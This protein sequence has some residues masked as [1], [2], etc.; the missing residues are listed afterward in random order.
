[1]LARAT[2]SIALLLSACAAPADGEM[3]WVDGP[4]RLQQGPQSPVAPL[5]PDE[6]LPPDGVLRLDALPRVTGDSEGDHAG[7]TVAGAGDLNGDGLDDLVVGSWEDDEGG[8]LAGAAFVFHGPVTGRLDPA[9]AQA[10]VVGAAPGDHAGWSV[11]GAGDVNGDGFGDLVVGAHGSHAG[12]S[13]AGAAYLLLGPLEGTIHLADAD[14]ILLG[15]SWFDAA[16][17]SVDGAG[18]VNGD[19]FDD[20]VVGAYQDDTGGTDAGAAFVVYGPIEGEH[21]LDEVGQRLSG[22]DE[23]DWAGYA[24]RGAGDLNDDGLDDVLVSAVGRSRE[25]TDAGAVYVV[26]GPVDSDRSLAS[27]DAVVLGARASDRAGHA[28]AVAEDATGDGRPDLLVGAWG[29]DAEGDEAGGAWLVPGPFSGTVDLRSQ[30]LAFGGGEPGDRLGVSVASTDWNGDGVSDV[31]IGSLEGEG[32]TEGAAWIFLGPLGAGRSVDDADLRIE[33]E[34]VGDR[35]G[36]ALAGAG[37][38]DGDGGDD[39]IVGAHG[40]SGAVDGCGAA[41]VVPGR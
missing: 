34:V 1:M 22:V 24:V 7:W 31:V 14:A 20:L 8:D 15:A 29:H 27:A 41:Y 9:V 6:G 37:D 17:I 3:A 16:G 28:L 21:R 4:P 33:G 39:L 26:F 11:A 38:L 25:G 13:G 2:I 40:A 19:G 18:D 32:A 10:K 12:G 30:G 36:F 23:G 35:A 5:D